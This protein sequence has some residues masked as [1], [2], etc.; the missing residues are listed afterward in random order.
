MTS[1]P[2]PQ[3]TIERIDATTLAHDQLERVDGLLSRIRLMVDMETLQG[4][5]T[6]QLRKLVLLGEALFGHARCL[7]YPRNRKH[8]RIC[9]RDQAMANSAGHLLAIGCFEQDAM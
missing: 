2:P 3:R 1:E 5:Y 9:P 8:D 4:S 7:A 6:I